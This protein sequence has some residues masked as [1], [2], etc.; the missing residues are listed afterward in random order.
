MPTPWRRGV[1]V[2]ISDEHDGCHGSMRLILHRGYVSCEFTGEHRATQ[3]VCCVTHCSSYDDSVAAFYRLLLTSLHEI[4]AVMHGT[5]ISQSASAFIAQPNYTETG[6]G[7]E[8]A[9]ITVNT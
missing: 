6:Y 9:Y 1:R 5:S 2:R 8:D 4:Q 7:P 3:N